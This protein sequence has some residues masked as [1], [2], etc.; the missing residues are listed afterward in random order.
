MPSLRVTLATKMTEENTDRL[1]FQELEALM[2]SDYK[3]NN[4]SSCLKPEPSIK[5]SK[6]IFQKGD[7][8][9]AVRRPMDMTHKT[10]DKF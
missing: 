1:R 5:R 3:L 8:V 10:K 2:K 4:A 9:I 7:L 6:R